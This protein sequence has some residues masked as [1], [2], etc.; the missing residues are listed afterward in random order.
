[1]SSL[2]LVLALL[3][4]IQQEVKLMEWHPS[5][6]TRTRIRVIKLNFCEIL[7]KRKKILFE[8]ARN[9]KSG[10]KSREMELS[11]SSREVHVIRVRVFG[12]LPIVV[13]FSVIISHLY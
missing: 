4:I 12:V 11:S 10:V 7:I 5:G 6:V 1:M 9:F 2:L 8:L 13:Y 3:P